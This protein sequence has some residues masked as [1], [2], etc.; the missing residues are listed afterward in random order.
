M[1]GDGTEDTDDETSNGGPGAGARRVAMD[2][3]P[4]LSVPL[5][6]G[7]PPR[8]R[9]VAT[10]LDRASVFVG[11][12]LTSRPTLRLGA[13]AYMAVLHLAVLMVLLLVMGGRCAGRG[14]AAPHLARAL[15]P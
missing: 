7:A 5:M 11:G 13:L 14:Q 2:F 6:R 8:L 15:V 3:R 4:L 10:Q 1:A 9:Q 12:W